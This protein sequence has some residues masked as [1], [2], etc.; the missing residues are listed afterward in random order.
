MESEGD[1]SKEKR[2][3]T[4]IV[5]FLNHLPFKISQGMYRALDALISRRSTRLDSFR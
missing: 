5:A 2:R 1:S 3:Q 4:E